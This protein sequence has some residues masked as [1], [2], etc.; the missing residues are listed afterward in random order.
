MAWIHPPALGCRFSFLHIPCGRCGHTAVLNGTSILIFGGF[1]GKKWL[2]DMHSFD[3]TSLVWTQPRVLGQAPIPRQYHSAVYSNNK[4]FIFGGYTGS[5]WLKDLVVLDSLGYKWIYPKVC[6]DVPNGREGHS[7]C[8]FENFI[9]V[10]GGWDGGT[11]GDVYRIGI[12]SYIWEKLEISGEKPLLCGHSMTLIDDNLFIFGGFDGANWVNSLYKIMIS[13]KK[14]EKILTRG[15]PIPRGYHTATLVN[16]YILVYAGYNGK[17][18][19]GDLVALDTTNLT[20]SMPDPCLGHFPT[21]RNAHTVTLLGSELFMFGGYNGVRDTDELHILETAAFS[22]LQDDLKS[23]QFLPIGETFSLQNLTSSLQIHS[24]IIKS[25]CPKLMDFFLQKKNFFLNVS[26]TALN[27]FA[28]YLY[29]DICIENIPAGVCEELLGLAKRFELERLCA[30]C[31]NN[32]DSVE[33]SFTMDVMS[34]REDRESSDIVVVIENKEFFLHKLIL[35]SRC[36]Y[37]KAMFQSG[38]AETHEKRMYLDYFT[39]SAFEFIVEWI[40][41]DKFTPLFGDV[42]LEIDEFIQIL[43]QSNMLGLDGLMR[44]AEIAVKELITMENAV[45]IYEIAHSLGAIRLKSYTINFILKELDKIS[46]KREIMEIND[47]AFEE[48][49]RY[50]PRRIKRQT[51]KKGVFPVLSLVKFDKNPLIGN[52]NVKPHD[53][54]SVRVPSREDKGILSMRN[55]LNSFSVKNLTHFLSP[56]PKKTVRSQKRASTFQ[57]KHVKD[58]EPPDFIVQGVSPRC[59]KSVE[60][61]SVLKLTGL[62]ISSS[63]SALYQHNYYDANTASRFLLYK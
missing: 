14:C 34:I 44:I 10:Y 3:T 60:R 46:I 36:P 31:E 20:W 15:E 48:L 9:Y 28:E 40:Y 5:A 11:I 57:Y 21:A 8:I 19:L 45:K 17:F 55:P 25:R 38:L 26:K 12:S 41:S 37:F 35:A 23:S 42:K 13:E 6:G 43:M 33:S 22:T 27:L 18:I 63:L 32:L 54:K 4:M 29:S 61:P 53:P 58:L 1:D 52:V 30:L 49:N 2:N 47:E 16:R 51:S 24:A 59:H 62:Q 39:A 7:M 50:L 56:Q